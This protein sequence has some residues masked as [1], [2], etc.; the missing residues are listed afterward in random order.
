MP[1]AF[2]SKGVEQCCKLSAVRYGILEHLLSY[3][4]IGDPWLQV[5]RITRS[6]RAEGGVISKEIKRIFQIVGEIINENQKKHRA[7]NTALNSS[8]DRKR[9]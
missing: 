3:V 5:S 9:G 6:E 1:C 2:G 8:L 7:Q 4:R